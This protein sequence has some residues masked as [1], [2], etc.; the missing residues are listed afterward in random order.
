MDKFDK[1]IL[2]IFIVA[3]IVAT[4]SL[5]SCNGYRI[6]ANNEP[7]SLKDTVRLVD[8]YVKTIKP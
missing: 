8:R 3:A 1:F 7:Q 2:G 5:S 6:I 4:M